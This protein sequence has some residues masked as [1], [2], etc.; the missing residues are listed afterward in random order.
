VSAVETLDDLLERA[1]Y[2]RRTSP[3]GVGAALGPEI[4][5]PGRDGRRWECLITDTVRGHRM[6]L[7]DAPRLPHDTQL[8]DL[9]RRSPDQRRAVP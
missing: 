8:D 7:V 4:T 6:I 5:E 9:E 3:C 2:R 1:T